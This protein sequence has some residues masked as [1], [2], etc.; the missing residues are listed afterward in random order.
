MDRPALPTGTIAAGTLGFAALGL[1]PGRLARVRGSDA[2]MAHDLGNAP[3]I[4]AAP[5]AGLAQ[6]VLHDLGARVLGRRTPRVGLLAA[7][8][9]VSTVGSR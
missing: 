8:L 6:R 9:A 1:D 4:P 5:R 7:A 3:L 2:G